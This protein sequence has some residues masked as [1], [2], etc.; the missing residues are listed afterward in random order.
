ML[1]GLRVELGTSDSPGW[2]ESMSLGLTDLPSQALAF[3][4]SLSECSE[5][6]IALG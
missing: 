1:W 2:G 4:S 6:P 3:A 5:A